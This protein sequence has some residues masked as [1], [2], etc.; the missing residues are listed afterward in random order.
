MPELRRSEPGESGSDLTQWQQEV[1]YFHCLEQP[2]VIEVVMEPERDNAPFAEIT[3]EFEFPEIQP[4]E[5]SD[6]H[7]FL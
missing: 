4:P 7:L 5:M 1:G 6:K 3:V 2:A